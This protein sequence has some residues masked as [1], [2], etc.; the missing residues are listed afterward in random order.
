MITNEVLDEK[1]RVQKAQAQ[2]VEYDLV[3]RMAASHHGVQAFSESTGVKFTY[4]HPTSSR[5]TK[6]Q[7]QL[8]EE[9]GLVNAIRQGQQSDLIDRE[10]VF[11]ML[12]KPRV[13]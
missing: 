8:D 13:K 9:I 4:G 6:I 12:D 1:Y 2:E 11:A 10:T 3:R 7:P 5:L